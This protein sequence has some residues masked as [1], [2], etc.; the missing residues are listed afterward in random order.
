M[1]RWR[2]RMGIGL[3]SVA[4]LCVIALAALSLLEIQIPNRSLIGLRAERFEDV[5]IRIKFNPDDPEARKHWL[6]DVGL[7]N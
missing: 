7:D 2:R 5:A 4:L 1:P 3:G 6:K